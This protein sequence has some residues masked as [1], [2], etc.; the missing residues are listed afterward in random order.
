MTLVL[1]GTF[2]VAMVGAGYLVELIF[3]AADLI[4][5]RGHAM[6]MDEGIS[7]LRMMG[8]APGGDEHSAGHHHAN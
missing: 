5:E 6:V 4:P 8:G 2:Y 1:L 3:G 7:M